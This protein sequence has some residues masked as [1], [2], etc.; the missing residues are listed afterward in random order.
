QIQNDD[1]PKRD[2]TAAALTI[3][4]PLDLLPSAR[5]ATNSA[6]RIGPALIV[7]TISNGKFWKS[8]KSR[9]A[10]FPHDQNRRRRHGQRPCSEAGGGWRGPGGS[11]IWHS[12]RA[13][14]VDGQNP[15]DTCRTSD[16]RFA[17]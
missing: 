3:I 1:I 6:S 7:A 11:R 9:F 16:R 10:N 4:W 8:L 13:G 17:D 2:A 12:H 14:R 15:F 5:T